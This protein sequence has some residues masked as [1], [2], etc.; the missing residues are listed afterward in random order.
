MHRSL[1]LEPD[2]I[3]LTVGFSSDRQ[4]KPGSTEVVTANPAGIGIP[5]RSA[6]APV[7]FISYL[8]GI[9]DEVERAVPGIRGL[10]LVNDIA[11]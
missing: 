11:W 3:W 5:R 2:L 7:L 8:A 4:V 9:F 6:A 10:S 1:E